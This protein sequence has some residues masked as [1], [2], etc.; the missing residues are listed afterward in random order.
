[1]DAFPVTFTDVQLEAAE[2]HLW[3]PGETVC[4]AAPACCSLWLVLEGCLEAG[5]AGR[6]WEAHAGAVLLLP[7]NVAHDIVTARGALSLSVR[8]RAT[9]FGRFDLLESLHP[10]VLGRPDPE[11]RRA[12]QGWTEQLI[13]LRRA[14]RQEQGAAALIGEGLARALFGLCWQ[15]LG[16]G[17]LAQPAAHPAPEW[18]Q[19]ALERIRREPGVRLEVLSRDLG[20]SSLRLRRGFH[21]FLNISPQAYLTRARLE[22]ARCLLAMTDLSVG[23]VAEMVGFESL[24]HFSSLFKQTYGQAPSLYRRFAASSP[25]GSPSDWSLPRHPE[26]KQ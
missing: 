20:V 16:G 19:A 11:Q 13:A 15:M 26:R 24:P 17:D 18:L 23:A 12:L 5:I 7:G 10:P 3:R 6:R 2:R 14:G 4:G 21:K 25:A 8:L 9:L 22:E 1:M